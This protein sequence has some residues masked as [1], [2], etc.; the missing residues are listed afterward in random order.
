MPYYPLF[1]SLLFCEDPSSKLGDIGQRAGYI[2]FTNP[3]CVMFSNPRFAP[4]AF[5]MGQ[6]KQLKSLTF[7]ENLISLLHLIRIRFDIGV[8]YFR[9]G[10]SSITVKPILNCLLG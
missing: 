7:P 10:H 2:A 1:G 4:F 8:L 9:I 6:G 5:A 3:Q